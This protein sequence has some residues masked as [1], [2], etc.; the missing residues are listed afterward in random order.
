MRFNLLIKLDFLIKK[1]AKIN[2][3]ERKFKVVKLHNVLLKKFIICL[4][5]KLILQNF[6]TIN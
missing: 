1:S 3:L 2:Q 5:H 4:Y 6:N